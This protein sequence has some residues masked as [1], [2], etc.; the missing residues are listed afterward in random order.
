MGR[1]ARPEPRGDV[2]VLLAR[3][4]FQRFAPRP[5]VMYVADKNG[6]IGDVDRQDVEKLVKAGAKPIAKRQSALLR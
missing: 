4:P 6:R 2:I 3:A 1:L 5:G